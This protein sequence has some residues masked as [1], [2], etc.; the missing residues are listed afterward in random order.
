MRAITSPKSSVLVTVTRLVTRHPHHR[1]SPRGKMDA[2]IPLME[3][4]V[5]ECRRFEENV[6]KL[7]RVNGAVGSFNHAFGHV[8]AG[9]RL[10]A[11]CV[12]F[13]ATQHS[14]PTEI[15]QKQRGD[16]SGAG[17]RDTS[18]A[19]GSV[20]AT[21]AVGSESNT[22][23]SAQVCVASHDHFLAPAHVVHVWC[24]TV[25]AGG[26]GGMLICAGS[27]GSTQQRRQAFDEETRTAVQDCG[28]PTVASCVAPLH[29]VQGRGG[30]FPQ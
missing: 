20:A 22:P 28:P 1:Q 25:L 30:S 27:G 18:N 24:D 4:L 17:A 26:G 5:G 6:R 15:G 8:L 9:V 2:V 29:Q 7:A 14:Q 3:R 23:R 12:E 13:G 19:G 16:A 21:A 10:Q 11:S